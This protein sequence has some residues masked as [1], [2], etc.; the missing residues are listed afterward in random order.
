M[1]LVSNEGLGGSGASAARASDTF[2]PSTLNID[3]LQ[4]ISAHTG[5]V[6]CP[7]AGCMNDPDLGPDSSTS[8]LDA[9]IDGTGGT[10]AGKPVWT[11]EQVIANLN[12]T[13]A[14]WAPG[15]NHPTPSSGSVSEIRYGFFDT[16]EQVE[17]N[18]YT[19]ELNGSYYGLA[20]Y[21]N[22]AAFNA[23]QRAATRESMQAWDDLIAP[24][25]VETSADVADL[26]FG[27]LASAPTTQAYARLPSTVMSNNPTVNAQIAEIS[28]DVWVSASQ[29]SNFQLD[30]GG[31]GIHTLV[32]EAGHAL[33][34]SHPGAY[35]AA[36]GLSITYPANA[37][38]AQDTRA[39]TVMSYFNAS[40]LGGARHFDF[41]ISTTVYAATPLIH[42]IATIQAIYGA[43]TT[44]RTGDTVYGFNSN[45]GRDSYDFT[46]TPA[47]VMAIYDAGGIDT[48]DASGYDT[49]QLIDLTPGSLSSIGGVTAASAPSFEQTNANR[50]AL[51]FAPVARATYDANIAALRANPVVGR[52]TDNVG[53]AYG[54]T[55]ENAI[56]GSGA[57]AIIGNAANNRL[58]G[59]AGDDVLLG[60]EGNDILEGGEGAD[61]LD[62]GTGADLMTGGAGN[63]IYVVDSM[64]DRVVETASGGTDE[65]RTT[66]SAYTLQQHLENLTGLSSTGQSL[67]GNALNNAIQGG[68]GAD[69]L[70]GLAGNDQLRGG[71]GD[72]FVD[73]GAGDDFVYGDAGRDQLFGGS[74]VDTL[75]GGAD[76][77]LL[78]GGSG[79]DILIGGAGD[80]ILTGGTG[81][82]TF[83][84]GPGSG[85]DR[86]TDFRSGD[87]ID[88]SAMTAAGIGHTME[89]TGRNTL[90]SFEDGSSILLEG[91]GARDLRGDWFNDVAT[92][93]FGAAAWDAADVGKADLS[94]KVHGDWQLVA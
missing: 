8:P 37:E 50:A 55:I 12:R 30:E 2:Q 29:A 24:T 68:A 77:D 23:E 46:K 28:G 20:E 82:D 14:S 43:D 40:S 92:P 59:N 4:G 25:F 64:G 72:D 26:N 21:F 15:P 7:C 42:D 35:N 36:P 3:A 65:V 74:G 54:V 91:V 1:K 76:N 17:T 39:Y 47:P 11:L 51:G 84:F 57:D 31:Y 45:A 80:D 69:R 22:F 56:G 49:T 94:A 61:S 73:G 75:F 67:T 90:I 70:V 52:L 48:L 38:Y 18:G 88:W 5:Q 33:G 53:I 85:V 89:Q 83:V 6:G 32:H 19:Y 44:T 71:G 13:G 87:V 34:L 27:N 9:N 81:A 41:N 63:D 78:D 79:N 93:M 60:L 86:I 58:V 10:V 16:L 66:L 62:G